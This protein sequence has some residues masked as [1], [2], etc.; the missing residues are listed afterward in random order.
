M[1]REIVRAVVSASCWHFSLSAVALSNFAVSFAKFSLRC[2]R[3]K[4]RNRGAVKER[5]TRTGAKHLLKFYKN[6]NKFISTGK[7]MQVRVLPV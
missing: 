4:R 6:T 3:G 2:C 7:Q 5:E 1:A